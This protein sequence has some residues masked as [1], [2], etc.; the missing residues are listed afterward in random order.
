MQIGPKIGKL[1]GCARIAYIKLYFSP[2]I[3]RFLYLANTSSM[4]HLIGNLILLILL[5]TEPFYR[6]QLFHTNAL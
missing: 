3:S 1:R 6:V 5:F 2:Y 4:P